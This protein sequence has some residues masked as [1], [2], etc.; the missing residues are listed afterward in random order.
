MRLNLFIDI[1]V[2]DL[3]LTGHTR[4]LMDWKGKLG[5]ADVANSVDLLP[6]VKIWV[7]EDGEWIGK[8]V[9]SW[10]N[11]LELPNWIEVWSRSF[12]AYWPFDNDDFLHNL[13]P[14]HGRGHGYKIRRLFTNPECRFTVV[15]H[16]GSLSSFGFL[17]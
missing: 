9:Y 11:S 5:I 13:Q 14:Q 17:K 2:G 3:V 16:V 12:I 1:L 6:T 15:P 4:F 8:K 7:R 10:H